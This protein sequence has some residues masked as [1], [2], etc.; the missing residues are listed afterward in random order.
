MA[1]FVSKK[2]LLPLLDKRLQLCFYLVL[3]HPCGR[4][5]LGG[6]GHGVDAVAQL[7]QVGVDAGQVLAA[8]QHFSGGRAGGCRAGG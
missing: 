5:V 8:D 7:A 1:G 6:H 3:L 2:W 4:Q